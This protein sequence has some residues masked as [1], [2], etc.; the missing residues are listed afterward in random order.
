M[1]DEF[2]PNFDSRPIS[3]IDRSASESIMQS[4]GAHNFGSRRETNFLAGN[5]LVTG[6]DYE[7]TTNFN[8]LF[9]VNQSVLNQSQISLDGGPEQSNRAGQHYSMPLSQRENIM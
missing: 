4:Q 1:N 2:D 7:S 3:V 5:H 6:A 8:N 9:Q